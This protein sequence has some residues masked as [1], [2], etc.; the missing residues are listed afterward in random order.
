M[1][2]PPL[3][4]LPGPGRLRQQKEIIQMDLHEE[5][6]AIDGW[7]GYLVSDQGRVKSLKGKTPRVL[8][9]GRNQKGYRLVCLTNGPATMTRAVH[10]LVADAF[11]GPCPDGLQT[12]H[13]DGDKENCAV[14]NLAFGTASQN[15][16]D[17][18]VHGV[19]NQAS[20]T[21]CRN[22]HPYNEAN[23]RRL[24]DG[25]RECKI[26]RRETKRRF[27]DRRALRAASVPSERAA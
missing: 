14:S 20:K 24:A 18:V 9:P 1:T 19:H 21:R 13:L 27:L 8:R 7:P 11:L 4:S 15:T 10:R 23:T 12:R 2:K 3:Q 22:D 26:C 5:W 16:L 6:R 17:Q 25:S